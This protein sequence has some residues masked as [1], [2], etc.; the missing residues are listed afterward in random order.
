[1]ASND[2]TPE[3]LPESLVELLDQH[4]PETVAAIHR[5]CERLLEEHDL[6]D[7]LDERTYS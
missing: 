5:Y 7:E 2:S 4:E 1:M 6:E 3:E